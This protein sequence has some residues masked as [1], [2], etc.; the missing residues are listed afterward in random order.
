MP[1]LHQPVI[2]PKGDTQQRGN[3]RNHHRFRNNQTETW[4]RVIHTARMAPSCQRRARTEAAIVFATPSVVIASVISGSLLSQRYEG[5]ATITQA[6][7][8][9][10]P[11]RVDLKTSGVSTL[12]AQTKM[13]EM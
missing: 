4:L 8:N 12:P 11:N 7:S 5:I 6:V 2:R 13:I 1:T 3:D 10:Y 9:N